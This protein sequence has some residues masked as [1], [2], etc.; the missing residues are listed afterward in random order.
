V[1]ALGEEIG[2]REQPLRR[3]LSASSLSVGQ[4]SQVQHQRGY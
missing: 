4:P 2:Y 3:G 1:A